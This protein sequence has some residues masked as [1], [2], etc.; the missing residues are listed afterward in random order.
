MQGLLALRDWLEALG[1]KQVA[2]EATGVYWKP[3]WA[4][5]E[6]RFELM[7]VNAR[8]VKQVPGRKT[9][10]KDAQWLCQLLEAGLLRGSFVPPEPIRTL[11]NL[12]R[13]RKTQIHDRQRE[14]NRLHKMLEDAGIKLGCVATDILGKSGRDMLDALVAGHDRPRGAGRAGRGQLRKKIPALREALDGRFD[15]E[16]ALIVGQILAHIDYLDEAIERLSGRSRS[17]SPLSPAS[18]SC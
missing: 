6:D 13:Y 3:V 4:V 2:M 11:R 1:V 5:L 10:V 12:T 14:A 15:A 16:H 7:L 8:H 17:R 9:D 18:V